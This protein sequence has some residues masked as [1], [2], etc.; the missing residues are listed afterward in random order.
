M[1]FCANE[2][3]GTS[4]AFHSADLHLTKT[5]HG[6]SQLKVSL[7]AGMTQGYTHKK[8]LADSE[9]HLLLCCSNQPS[10]LLMAE[11]MTPEY[12]HPDLS[13]ER[14]ETLGDAFLKYDCCIHVYH[15]YLHAHEG[16]IIPHQEILQFSTC[17]VHCI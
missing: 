8:Q 13:F 10:L 5:E 11:A 1:H 2:S 4:E 6:V 15:A 3:W 14:L 9:P 16:K 12:S 7:Q 17:A